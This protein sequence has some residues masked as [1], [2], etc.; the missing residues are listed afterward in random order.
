M[1]ITIKKFNKIEKYTIHFLYFSSLRQN[2]EGFIGPIS[3][4]TNDK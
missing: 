4:T 3:F 1:Q 2:Q